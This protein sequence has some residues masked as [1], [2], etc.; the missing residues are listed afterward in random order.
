M[1]QG[2]W[3]GRALVQ[4][5]AHQEALRFGEGDWLALEQKER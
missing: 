1:W 4:H 5:L 2:Q 3:E